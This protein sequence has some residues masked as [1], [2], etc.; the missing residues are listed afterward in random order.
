M[1][2]VLTVN[3]VTVQFGGLVALDDVSF[4]VEAGEL[5]ALIG[6]NGAGKTT[7]INAMTGVYAPQ[8]GG[9]VSYAS[10]RGAVELT[11][12]RPHKIARMGIGRTFQNLGVFP[13]Q[14]VLNNLLLGRY[15]QGRSGAL[16]AGFRTRRV[17]REELESR[18]AVESVI[19]LLELAEFRTEPVGGLPY[20]VQK[21]VELGRVLAMEPQVLM[22]DEPMAGMSVDEKRDMVRYI[23]D[24]RAALGTTVVLIEHDMGVVMAIAERVMVLDFGKRIAL[25][26]ADEV[27]SDQ[28]VIDAYL[29]AGDSTATGAAR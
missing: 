10:E 9:S 17:R 19:E 3:N 29:G 6:P 23:E 21:R 26:R 14:S 12:F 27:Q 7:L 8:P 24:I 16:G 20:G 18:E 11:K 2:S 25:G 22:L 5:F 4:T 28:R 13:S 1:T 15:F